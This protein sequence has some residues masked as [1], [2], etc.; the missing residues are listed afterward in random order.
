MAEKLSI[1]HDF[2]VDMQWPASAGTGGNPLV[3]ETIARLQILVGGTSVTSYQSDKGDKGDHLPLPTYY[4]AEWLAQNWWAFLYEPRKQERADAEADFRKRHWLAIAR[5]G[6]A[7]PDV[8]FAP[9]GEAIEISA[10]PSY[11][12][13]ARLNFMGEATALVP[14]AKVR[15]E[16]STFV[17]NVIERLNQKGITKSDAHTAWQKVKSTSSE[18][19]TYCRLIGSLGLCPYVDHPNIDRELDTISDKISASMLSDLCDASN[20]ANFQ[21]VAKLTDDI[22]V[23]LDKAQP[24]KVR[25]LINVDRPSDSRPRAYEWGYRATEA[26]RKAL[27]IANDDP[28]GH[29]VFFARLQFDPA[30]VVEDGFEPVNT[31]L[32]SAV[33]T[34]TDDSMKLATVGANEAQ[35]KFAAARASFLTWSHD[36][37]ASHLVTTAKTRAQ[38]A[39]RAF[40]AE[41]LAPVK[42]LRKRLGERG[43]VSSFTLDKVSEEIG[44]ASSVVRY[45]VQ[46][47]GFFIAEAA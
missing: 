4:V 8:M 10:R 40:A 37:E 15:T 39:S 13:F 1:A 30:N 38:Q 47:D 12:R 27:G 9:T 21:R 42:F 29:K 23:K 35:R 14:T 34:R 17:D 24:L 26:A 43:E 28:F 25:E 31:P 44:V 18:E 36:E 5:N 46:N 7:L 20:M 22:Y 19:E 3:D 16:L 11:L 41:L 32:V 45:Q 33:V 2:A 6:F